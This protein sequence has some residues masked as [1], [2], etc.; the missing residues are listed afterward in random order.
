MD[1]VTGLWAAITTSTAPGG[2]TINLRPLLHISEHSVLE[3]P[4]TLI[5]AS[6]LYGAW[7]GVL[8]PNCS[9]PA[10][11]VNGTVLGGKPVGGKPVAGGLK[12]FDQRVN[13]SGT[14]AGENAVTWAQLTLTPSP[15]LTLTLNL[16]LTLTLTLT[17]TL[18][19]NLARFTSRSHSNHI[20]IT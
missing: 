17:Q 3:Y 9:K 1:A 11:T 13:L 6:Q 20:A 2:S 14:D 15:T 19:L 16:A 4:Y 7:T 18:T 12:I 10:R 8:Y 5:T